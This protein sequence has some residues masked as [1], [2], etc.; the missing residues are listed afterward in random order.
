[1]PGLAA[2]VEEIAAQSDPDRSL[3]PLI[4]HCW[5]AAPLPQLAM[6][7]L[8]PVAYLARTRHSPSSALVT[9]P[10]VRWVT[11]DCAGSMNGV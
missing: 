10:A 7:T 11:A 8:P 6:T 4:D 3:P 1:M 2:D 5:L 9:V